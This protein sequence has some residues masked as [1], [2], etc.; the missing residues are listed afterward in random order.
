MIR[1]RQEGKPAR[2]GRQ[3][4]NED[5]Y[6]IHRTLR[7]LSLAQREMHQWGCKKGASFP[8]VLVQELTPYPLS[9][10][11]FSLQGHPLCPGRVRLHNNVTLTMSKHKT[12]S[13]PLSSPEGSKDPSYDQGKQTKTA[14]H[15]SISVSAQFR[16]TLNSSYLTCS[17]PWIPNPMARQKRF[18]LKKDECVELRISCTW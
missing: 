11:P 7:L 13:S 10:S 14:P 2:A 15:G 6:N 3:S 5:R 17:T 18:L 1:Y 4:E 16:Q 9:P 12:R 8:D